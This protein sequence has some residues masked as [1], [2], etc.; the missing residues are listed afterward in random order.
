[1]KVKCDFSKYLPQSNKKLFKCKSLKGPLRD[2]SAED[3]D[4]RLYNQD[5]NARGKSAAKVK[6]LKIFVNKSKNLITY[7]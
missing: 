1:L 2:Q 4:K 7:L 6:K 5:K 3:V